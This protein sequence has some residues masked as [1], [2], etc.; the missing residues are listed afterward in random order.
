MVDD[1][2]GIIYFGLAKESSHGKPR[3]CGGLGTVAGHSGQRGG[4]VPGL[5]TVAGH[6]GQRGG[7][8]SGTRSIGKKYI[9]WTATIY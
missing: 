9:N 1:V 3:Q 7:K 5:G 4:K 2:Y 6:S 8:S